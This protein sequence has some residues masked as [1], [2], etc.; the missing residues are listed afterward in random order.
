MII[1][2]AISTEMIGNNDC[3]SELDSPSHMALIGRALFSKRNSE[4]WGHGISADDC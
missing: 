4:P 2:K 3:F 1:P